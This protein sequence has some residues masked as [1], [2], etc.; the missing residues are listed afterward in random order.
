MTEHRPTNDTSDL[1]HPD[2]SRTVVWVR[3]G[4]IRL[5]V[6]GSAAVLAA[7]GGAVAGAAAD[8]HR[9]APPADHTSISK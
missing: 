9:A 2:G 3:N 5:A 7:S 1:E 8:Q 4:R 6:L